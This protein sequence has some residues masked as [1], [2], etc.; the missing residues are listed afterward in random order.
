ML[1]R[2][3]AYGEAN[4]LLS[5]L[6]EDIRQEVLSACTPTKLTLGDTLVSAGGPIKRVFFLSS[7]IAS[8]VLVSRSG[9]KTEAGIIGKEGFVP[10]G[11]VA[12]AKTSVTEIIVQAPG[13][14]LAIDIQPFTALLAKYRVF[15]EIMTCALHVSRT[16]VECT[17]SSNATQTVNQRLARWL[18]MCDDRVN[19]DLQLTHDFLSMMLAVRRPSVTDALHVLESRGFIRSER[20][21][22]TVRNREAL[23]LYA[24]DLYGLPEDEGARAFARFLPIDKAEAPM[25]DLSVVR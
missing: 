12:G 19:G 20:A 1:K 5:L 7:G 22:I 14:A 8:V 25:E 15:S 24:Q 13:E 4:F 11:A 18:L 17:A 10:A 9:R 3:E 6:D 21:K 23:T 2:S 16:Q